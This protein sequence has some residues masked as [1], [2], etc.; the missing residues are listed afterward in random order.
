MFN[1]IK[2]L[3]NFKNLVL[4]FPVALI[5]VKIIGNLILFFILLVGIK[6]YFI[7]N[8]QPF[9]IPATKMISI[10]SIAYFSIM[11]LSIIFN[12]GFNEEIKHIA[13]KLHFLLLPIISLAFLGFKIDV[14][15]IIMSIKIG[16][17]SIGLIIFFQG[18]FSHEGFIDLIWDEGRLSGMINSNVSGDIM[19][20]MFF[21]SIVRFFDENK[22]ELLLTFIS[23]S[24]GLFGILSSGS[25]GS[26]LTFTILAIIL[27][28]L[29]FKKI[30]FVYHNK[31]SLLYGVGLFLISSL[32]VFAPKI[33]ITFQ[34]TLSNVL[35]WADNEE[36]YSS[37]GIRLEMWQDSLEAF[38]DA[39]WYGYGYR[40]ANSKVSEYSQNHS[41]VISSFTHL[42]N[43]YI[44]A[45]LSAGFPGLF[46]LILIL[47][48]PMSIFF[49]SRHYEENYYVSIMGI[50][51]TM[52]YAISGI[53]HIA[54]GEEHLNAFYVFY[55]L[56]LLNLIV[57]NKNNKE[58]R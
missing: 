52:G 57:N 47:F 37:S 9:K 17:I 25:R 1:Y 12:A 16:L 36:I 49:K 44:T 24:F 34:H 54:F 8:Y 27:F 13:R 23:S 3:L 45:L 35:I 26:W 55:I 22:K 39:P 31:K 58:L 7:N 53:T 11:L 14:K 38:K 10:I 19:V 32:I 56:L 30:L 29:K 20:L 18:F 46:L 33:H 21:M 41:E 4:I 50:V 28:F 40:L 51:L 5:S 42:H 6:N 15:A 48:V 43:E 2:D